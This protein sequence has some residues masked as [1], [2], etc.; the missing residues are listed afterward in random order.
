MHKLMDDKSVKGSQAVFS[1]QFTLSDQT[2]RTGQGQFPMVT[3]RNA[4]IRENILNCGPPTLQLKLTGP[5]SKN[6]TAARSFLTSVSHFGFLNKCIVN[7]EVE[8]YGMASYRYQCRGK[9]EIFLVSYDDIKKYFS[10]VDVAKKLDKDLLTVIK[11][12]L[13]TMSPDIAADFVASCGVIYRG[14]VCICNK[15][16]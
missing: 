6:V 13:T 9:R 11:E 7:G 8:R 14:E 12:I 1:V 4:A 15:Y 16:Q 10:L 3:P 5:A 2:K